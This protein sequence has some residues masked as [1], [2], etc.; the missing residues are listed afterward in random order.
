MDIKNLID[1][2]SFIEV[3]SCSTSL[4]IL[5]LGYILIL[6]LKL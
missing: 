6:D 3:G 1:I 5:V 2:K 4:Y